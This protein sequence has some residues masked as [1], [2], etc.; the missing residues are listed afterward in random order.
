M[1][2]CVSRLEELYT[3]R[4]FFGEKHRLSFHFFIFR[5]VVRLI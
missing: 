1:C 2:E 4:F 3:Q 5:D